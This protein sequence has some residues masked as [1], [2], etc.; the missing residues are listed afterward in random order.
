MPLLC[1]LF[2]RL[3]DLPRQSQRVLYRQWPL[4][5]LAFDKFHDQVVRPNVMQRANIRVVQRGD[6]VGLLLETRCVF[7][8]QSLDGDDAVEPGVTGFHTS[9][10]PPSPMGASSS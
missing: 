2:E 9:P 6:R 5:R 1:G 3:R 10:I 7:A 4:K 8:L